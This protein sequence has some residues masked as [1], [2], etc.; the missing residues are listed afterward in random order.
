MRIILVC[1]LLIVFGFYKA[2][3]IDANGKKQGYWK[4][5]DDKTNALIYEGMFKD[6][7]PIGTFKYYYPHDTVRAIMVFRQDGK[8]ASARLFHINGKRMA[9][10]NYVNKE[11]KDST[12]TYYDEDGKL[13]SSENYKMGKKH[14]VSAVYLQDGK[15]SEEVNFK[16]GL[17]NG[18][19][20]KYFD[21]VSLRGKGQYVN[22]LLDGKIC[23]YFPNGVEAAAGYYS[24]G[25]KTG[26]WIYKNQDGKIKEKEL[27]KNGKLASKKETEAFFSKNK[28]ESTNQSTVAPKSTSTNTVQK[29]TPKT[30]K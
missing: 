8:T 14:G 15:L 3:T 11:I 1:L 18:P 27:Y 6:D 21:G 12:W 30:K 22:G 4:K 13:I 17:E 25:I 9:Q 5:K 19:Y 10:G 28:V 29:V 20:K 24:K 26:V 7:K 16:D 2:Q 23:H